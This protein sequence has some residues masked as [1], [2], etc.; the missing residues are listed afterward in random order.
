MIRPIF[1]YPLTPICVMSETNKRKLQKFQNGNITQIHYRGNRRLVI[2]ENDEEEERPN[3]QELHNRYKLEPI[4]VRL[5]R[6]AKDSW[7]RFRNVYPEIATRSETIE[8]QQGEEVNK[9]HLWWPRVAKYI[10]R[11]EPQPIY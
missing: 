1:E 11:D 7:E 3:I 9:D 2:E 8:I 5:F 6:R 10:A 4:N